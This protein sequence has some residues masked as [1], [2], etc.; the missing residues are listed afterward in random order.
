MRLV[1][2]SKENLRMAVVKI[3]STDEVMKAGKLVVSAN[4]K[5]VG[6]FHF[7]GKFYAWLNR[8][9]HQGGPVCQGRMFNLVEEV[10]DETQCSHG[11]TYNQ[12]KLNI[13]CPWHGVEF[14][15]ETGRSTCAQR[16]SL[17]PVK[18]FVEQDQVHLDL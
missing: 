18:L 2:V 13:V 15:V 9:P 8:C 5:E 10:V 11:R 7:R 12:E 1:L 17:R 14:D 3:G 4:G 6:I 16:F